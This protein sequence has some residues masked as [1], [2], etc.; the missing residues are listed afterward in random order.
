MRKVSPNLS[1]KLKLKTI[2]DFQFG[3]GAGNA[4]F[5]EEITIER[6]KGTNRIRFVY[7]AD[8][9]V[10]SFRVKDGYLVPS[11][12]GARLLYENTLGLKVKVNQDAEPFVREGK[13][14]YCKHVI[15]ADANISV[16]EE[17]IIVNEKEEFIGIGT[18]KIAGLLMKEMKS[19]VAVDTRKGV[20]IG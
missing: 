1:E 2:A 15:E 6:S 18:A 3:K 7:L 12:M 4:L 9:R 14:V 8:E 17:V 11:L 16:K 13:S 20:G 5:S 10:C 19:G